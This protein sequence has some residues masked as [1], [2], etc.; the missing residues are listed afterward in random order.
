MINLK[1]IRQVFLFIFF[2]PLFSFAQDCDHFGESYCT[3]PFDWDYEIN[4]QSMNIAMFEGQAFK[5][6]S[7]FYEGYDYYIGFCAHQELGAVEYRL[8]STDVYL[9]K[10]FSDDNSSRL[11]HIEFTN[12]ATRIMIIEVKVPRKNSYIDT[13]NKQCVGIIIGQKKTVKDF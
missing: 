1:Y 6:S 2:L 3:L 10:K 4:S 9:D 7:V 8:L 11:E 13:N 5:F 12:K